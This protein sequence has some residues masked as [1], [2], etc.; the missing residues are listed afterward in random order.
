MEKIEWAQ[1]S[2][3][4]SLYTL[5]STTGY[6]SYCYMSQIATQVKAE[7]PVFG[8]DN[9]LDNIFGLPVSITSFWLPD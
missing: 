7:V 4:R 8:G 3:F 6:Q 9:Q 2:S 5:S 1:G